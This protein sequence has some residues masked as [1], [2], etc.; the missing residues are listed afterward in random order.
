MEAFLPSTPT[1]TTTTTTT[2][3]TSLGSTAVGA[4]LLDDDFETPLKPTE[5][6]A[7]K[8]SSDKSPESILPF[9]SQDDSAKPKKRKKI[10]V[11]QGL[12]ALKTL[13]DAIYEQTDPST[14]DE[15]FVVKPKLLKIPLVISIALTSQ[16][17]ARP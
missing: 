4:D 5:K 9:L 6:K 8:K 3:T 13:Q 17:T 10:P 1:S 2:T 15:Q 7:K 14:K 16:Q 11:H 12:S